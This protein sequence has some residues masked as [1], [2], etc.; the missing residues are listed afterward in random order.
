MSLHPTQTAGIPACPPPEVLEAMAV[1]AEACDRL[2]ETGRTVRFTTGLGRLSIH[3]IDGRG[4]VA[5]T[6]SPTQL[7]DLAGGGAID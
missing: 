7:L 6:L 3:L 1:A 5:Q 4:A 2:A